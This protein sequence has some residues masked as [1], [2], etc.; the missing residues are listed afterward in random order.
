MKNDTY[1]ILLAGFGGQGILFMGKQIATAAMNENL[2]VSWLPSYGP[3]MRGGSANCSVI[4]SESE[5]G[6][7][8]VTE[9]D[10]L[11]AMNRPSFLKFEPKVAKGGMVVVNSTLVE[12]RSTRDDIEAKYIPATRMADENGLA[13]GANMIM[14][15]YLLKLT[16]MFELEPFIKHVV[17]DIPAARAHLAEANRKA[18]TL[19]YNYA[20]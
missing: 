6:S 16:G 10:I 12:D 3:E 8:V 19:G 5:I 20:E 14:L 18:L 9:P 13:G 11:V 15:G 17:D 2:E 4:V 7:P 1:R